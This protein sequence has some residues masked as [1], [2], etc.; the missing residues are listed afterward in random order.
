MILNEKDERMSDIWLAL[1]KSFVKT[2]IPSTTS[3]TWDPIKS[4]SSRKYL[5]LNLNSVMEYPIET[6]ANMEFWDNL[7]PDLEKIRGKKSNYGRNAP[8]ILSLFFTIV[9]LFLM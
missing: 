4:A 8:S 5:N 7:I 9:Y 6:K 1:W 2:G 3:I